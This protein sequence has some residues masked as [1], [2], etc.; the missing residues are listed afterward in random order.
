MKTNIIKA[1]IGAAGVIGTI[2]GINTTRRM[3]Q[4]VD[5]MTEVERL[6]MQAQSG[7]ALLALPDNRYS[8]PQQAV[9]GP[10]DVQASL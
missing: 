9:A 1:A 4:T 10:E 8:D 2:V 6:R 7:A 3:N 5:C